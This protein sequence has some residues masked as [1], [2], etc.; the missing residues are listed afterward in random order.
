MWRHVRKHERVPIAITKLFFKSDDKSNHHHAQKY[1]HTLSVTH[2]LAHTHTRTRTHTCTRTPTCTCTCNHTVSLS[3]THTV[4]HTLTLTLTDTLTLL[5]CSASAETS[6]HAIPAATP[7]QRPRHELAWIWTD[8]L[9]EQRRATSLVETAGGAA[10]AGSKTTACM[11]LAQDSRQ[12]RN[13]FHGKEAA[14]QLNKAR[15]HESICIF[16][17]ESALIDCYCY[18]VKQ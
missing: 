12:V 1:T 10:R 7:Q 15:I 5:W 2:T 16:C 18:Y 4:S 14:A 11:M 17:R 6:T 9:S 8:F 13:S 3:H